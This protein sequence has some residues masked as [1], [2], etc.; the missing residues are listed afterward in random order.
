[1]NIKKLF[2]LLLTITVSMLSM[3]QGLHLGA[4]AGVNLLKVDGK[5]FSEE[6][7]FGYNLGAFAEI[8]FN[9]KWGIQPEVLWNQTNTRTTGE[10]SE[11]YPTSTADI[12]DVKLNYLSIPILLNYRPIKLLTLQAGPQF[13]ILM[14][15]NKN[16]LQ[17]GK[18][19]F[20]KGDFA[21]LAGAQINLA[22][23]KLGGRYQ[24]G[25]SNINDID[26]Q[27]KWKNQGWQLYAGFRLF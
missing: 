13:G 3:A 24:I 17:N 23:V 9:K 6:F 27:D 5:S 1:M 4:K 12:K 19:A 2:L 16:L 8:N 15:G 20:K 26:N 21:M 25:L 18:E 22:G 7:R 10:F 14:D 11:I